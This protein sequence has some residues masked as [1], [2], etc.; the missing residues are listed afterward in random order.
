MLNFPKLRVGLIGC[1]AFGESHLATFAG[2]PY[3]E[4]TAVADASEERA[5]KL[6]TRYGV[7]RVVK[8]FR[9]LCAL[10]EVDAVSVVTTEDQHLEPVLAALGQ[11]KHV[12]V[13]KPLATRMEDAE[14]M[15]EA[16]RA[17]KRILMPGHLLRFETRYAAVK[18]Q[19]DS[20]R[21]GRVM[22]I[23]ARRNRPKWQGTNYK[24]TPLP[25]ETAIH[26]LDVI[27]WYCGNKV[28][29]VRAY[30]LALEPGAA[31]DLTC[32]ALR[33]EG[34]A[35]AFIQTAWLVPDK[36][37]ALDDFLQVVTSRGIA[38]IDIAN[39]GLSILG[40]DGI[41]L[42]DVVYEP[43]LRGAVFG[44]LREQLAYFALCAL[45]GNQ[46]TVVTAE[47]GLEAVRVAL[48]VVESARADR[49]I[50]LPSR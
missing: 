26:D 42:P 34:G 48:A 23:Y 16:A 33:F 19:L 17:N 20:G 39:S 45:D 27:L 28:K 13:E 9:E 44:A 8:D 46:P 14:K 4:V 37:P 35:V 32:A 49:E 10:R 1:G 40:E 2:I 29:S 21:L 36:S 3:V 11:G 38:N 7:P 47:D 24:R 6:A 18:E 15:L 31:A 22:Y 41:E 43:R 5:H 50:D 30:D 12:L 25:L